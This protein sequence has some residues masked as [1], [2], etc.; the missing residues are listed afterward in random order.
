ML[1]NY[2]RTAMTQAQYRV[3]PEDDSVYGEL[4]GFD[5]VQAYGDTLELC[6]HNLAES[7]EEWI[8]FRV[9][10]KLPLPP[11]DEC[12]EPSVSTPEKPGA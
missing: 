8:F 10:R 11:L 2:I 4:P 5:G 1:S 12:V 3:L 6:R 9:S 7:L